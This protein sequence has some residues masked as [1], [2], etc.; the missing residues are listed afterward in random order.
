LGKPASAEFGKSGSSGVRCRDGTTQGS[1][2]SIGDVGCRVADSVDHYL[3]PSAE[4]IG[5]RRSVAAIG[6]MQY[7]EARHVLQQ[8]AGEMQNDAG[9]GTVGELGWVRLAVGDEFLQIVDRRQD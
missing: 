9:R 6:N 5:Q 8:L 3:Q 2:F 7:L 1:Q 4:H